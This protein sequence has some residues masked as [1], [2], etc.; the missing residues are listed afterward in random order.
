MS[1][2]EEVGDPLDLAGG[3]AAKRS[4][5]IASE[6]AAT[7]LAES[8]R[9]FDIGQSRLEPFT[10]ESVP[11]FQQQAILSGARG[12]EAQA[13]AFQQFAESPATQFLRES[14]LALSSP[15]IEG[16]R[17]AELQRFNQGLALQ[18][19]GNQFNRLG[20]IAGS[21]QAA[22]STLVG[23][24]E[25]VAGRNIQQQQAAFQAQQQGQ[26]ARQAGRENLAN[27]AV[28]LGAAFAGGS[29]GG[30]GGAG[31]GNVGVSV[32]Q[33]NFRGFA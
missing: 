18:D 3:Q 23:L 32:N 26:A 5:R 31:G 19:F 6:A 4:E 10:A 7:N 9:Q 22:A 14:G 20:T 8:R 16:E 25:E 15:G 11:A 17:L 27:T 30:R 2:L 13:E 28:G 21:G 1:S 12:Q 33:Q 24:G 29:G